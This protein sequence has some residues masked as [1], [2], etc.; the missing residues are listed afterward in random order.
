[1][2]QWVRRRTTKRFWNEHGVALP[3]AMM[4]LVLLTTLML[5]F[6]ALSQTEPVIASNQ[7]RV[8]QARALAESGMEHA[9]WALTTGNVLPGE[10]IPAGAL[11]NP[12]PSNPAA[13]PFDGNA[14]SV[15]SSHGGYT[16]RVTTPDPV[17]QPLRR[18]IEAVG[19]VPTPSPS[20]ARRRIVASVQALPDL[21]LNAPCALCV[22]GDLDVQGNS[23]VDAR[24]DGLCGGTQPK[25]G[26]FTSGN[27]EQ[28]G[29][30]SIKG[31]AGTNPSGNQPGVDYAEGRPESDFA[32]FAFKDEH[33]DTLKELAKKNGTYFGPGF[34]GT[35]DNTTGAAQAGTWSGSVT[36]N[37]GNKL[38][39]GVVFIDTTSGL[40]IVSCP[41]GSPDSCIPTPDSHFAQVDIH[42]NPFVSGDFAGMIVVNGRL[43][44]SGNMRI[45]GLVYVLDDL[46]YNGT[47][48][49]EVSGLVISQNVRNQ[50]ATS[51]S[52]TDSLTGGNS[53]IRFNCAN[54]RGA[55]QAP[56]T[57]ALVPGTYREEPEP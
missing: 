39:N 49:G 50:T 18:Q 1:M 9:V 35:T 30:S 13:A 56:R 29:S 10:D 22:R 57:F 6:L 53:R 21:A 38:K 16:V 24:T 31:Q 20:S 51:I 43:S 11:A 33:L 7:F 25:Y 44:I 2:N 37:S 5:A 36:F 26:A 27:I 41:P 23:L 40:N 4:T 19:W 15:V 42:G 8:S 32:S 3:M 12:I 46:S 52:D 48:T 55:G 34:S 14:F 54:A 28:Q 17:G 45:G 47:G